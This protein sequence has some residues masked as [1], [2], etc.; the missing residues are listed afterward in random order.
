MLIRIKLT[1][2]VRSILSTVLIPGTVIFLIPSL[3]IAESGNSGPHELSI[4]SVAALI[5]GSL[6]L[7][8]LILSIRSFAVLGKGTLSPAD[9]PKDLVLKGPYRF[10]RNP[11]YM[12][13][14]LILLSEAIFFES[15]YLLIYLFIVGL[16]FHL[17]VVFYE[18]PK[19]KAV[20]GK[21]YSDYCKSVPRWTF[22]FKR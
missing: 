18:E 21:S 3:V 8:L 22:T 9:P 1:L 6:Q 15:I 5:F 2:L 16:V 19:L 12:A 14:V 11:M 10:T 13:A 17:F 7:I 4:I 20:F